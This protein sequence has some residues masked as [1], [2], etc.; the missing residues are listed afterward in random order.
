MVELTVKKIAGK[1]IDFSGSL[2]EFHEGCLGFEAVGFG[3]VPCA[4]SWAGPVSPLALLDGVALSQRHPPL[5]GKC[6]GRWWPSPRAVQFRPQTTIRL[7]VHPQTMRPSPQRWLFPACGATGAEV[8]NLTVPRG[9]RR[10]F[11]TLPHAFSC[12]AKTPATR[13]R[14]VCL[15]PDRGVPNPC[16]WHGVRPLSCRRV[17]QRP[18][19]SGRG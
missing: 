2:T 15:F 18:R 3:R 17:S 14:R 10:L 6:H 16:T 5:N 7:R 9:R 12:E 1:R 4:V 8:G 19:I 11:F 13:A